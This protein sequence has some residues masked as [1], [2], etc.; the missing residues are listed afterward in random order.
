MEN[1]KMLYCKRLI[2]FSSQRNSLSTWE[3]FCM[4]FSY[5]IEFSDEPKR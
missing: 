3:K 4:S 1:W 5:Y 2:K